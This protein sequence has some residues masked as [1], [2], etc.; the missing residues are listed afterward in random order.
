MSLV[1]RCNIQLRCFW[2]LW[3]C[4]DEKEL[5]MKGGA[6]DF[7]AIMS[8]KA[9][10]TAC[11]SKRDFDRLAKASARWKGLVATFP[12][13]KDYVSHTRNFPREVF[14]GLVVVLKVKGKIKKLA[15]Q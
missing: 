2:E 8:E 6:W 3:V 11:C 12:K 9:P 5:S 13:Y 15:Q 1:K 14:L 7:K 10:L 4:V